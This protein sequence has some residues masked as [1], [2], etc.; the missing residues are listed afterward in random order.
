MLSNLEAGR[1]YYF[2]VVSADP[3]GNQGISTDYK[4]QTE[5][6]PQTGQSPSQST[7]QTT[8]SES[9][10]TETIVNEINKITSPQKLQEILNQTIKA[11]KGIT[12]DLT[13]VGPPTVVPE[14]NSALVKWTTDR[15]SSGEVQFSPT[16][17]FS[18]GK[19][20]YSQS[21][22]DADTKD[23][24]IRLIGLEPYTNYSFQVQSKDSLGI[25]GYSLTIGH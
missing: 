16:E 4:I 18:E 17:G 15:D 20:Q 9:Q 23:H 10:T 22:T 2:R 24:E 21:S 3:S 1:T 5:G 7:T 13:I 14:T 12:E 11:I 19:F 6:T 25:T 8:Q